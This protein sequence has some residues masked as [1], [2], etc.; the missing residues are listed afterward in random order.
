MSDTIHSEGDI[1]LELSQAAIP[2]ATIAISEVDD[3]QQDDSTTPL[4]AGTQ[5]GNQD[6]NEGG[7]GEQP[8]E[9][10]D[11]RDDAIGM[12]AQTLLNIQNEISRPTSV[13]GFW[14]YV[15]LLCNL[16]Q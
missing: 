2:H 6:T 8:Q 16:T 15:L 9:G 7:Q 10:D 11:I 5:E 4:T 14:R 13:M 12:E 1:E 3:D